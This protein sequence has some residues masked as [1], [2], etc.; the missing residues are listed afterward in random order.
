[1]SDI[2]ET[3]ERMALLQDVLDSLEEAE[4]LRQ[5]LVVDMKTETDPMELEKYRQ[6]LKKFDTVIADKKDM[7]HNLAKGSVRLRGKRLPE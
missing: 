5:S 2:G 4:E 1:M 7:I 6:A 3:S